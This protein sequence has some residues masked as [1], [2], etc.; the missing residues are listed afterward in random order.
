MLVGSYEMTTDLGIPAFRST[1]LAREDDP[2]RPL[3]PSHGMGCHPDRGIA[4]FRSLVEAVQS[5][6]TRISS[7]RD[8]VPRAD[9]ELTRNPDALREARAR[10]V[11]TPAAR[12]F[13]QVPSFQGETFEQD[14]AWLL[15]R[16]A[17]AAGRVVFV[18]LSPPD[19][20]LS[21]VRV[22][23]EGLEGKPGGPGYRP[24]ERA[25]KGMRSWHDVAGRA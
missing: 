3:Y 8:D 6:L 15:D 18:D 19:F 24:S 16:L 22:V 1:I 14:L 9:Y 20:D 17:I 23:V 12:S 2:D 7:S 13:A 5:R 4:L 10:L 21:V 11:E 25:L